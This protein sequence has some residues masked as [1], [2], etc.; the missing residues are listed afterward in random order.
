MKSRFLLIGWFLL[1]I[2]LTAIEATAENCLPLVV[3]NPEGNYIVP[4][5]MGD[6]V[7]SRVNGTELSLDA[8]VQKRRVSRPAVVVIHGGG[9]T[10]GS[11]V[12][13]TGQFLEML[14]EAGYNWFA[15]DYRKNGSA[16]YQQSLAD[17]RAALQFIRCH[18]TAFRIDP[19]RIALLGED[20]G[21]Q[22]A[23]LL[24]ADQTEDVKASVLIGG[25]YDREELL[26]APGSRAATLVVHGSADREALPETAQ[27][28]C[29]AQ[30]A[31]GAVCDYVSVEGAIH[32][33][34]NWRPEQ[35]SYKQRVIRW[36]NRK[37][38]L[39]KPDFEPYYGTLRWRS[40]FVGYVNDSGKT[41]HL[42]LNLHIPS[43]PGPFPVVIL[44]HG[45]GWEAGDKVTYIAPLFEPLAKAGFAW[46]SIDYELTPKV[47]HESQL[48]NVRHAIDWIRNNASLSRLD[49]ERIALIGESA[50]GQMVAQLATESPRG[51][52]AVVSFY[53]VYDFTQMAKDLSPRSIPVRL[54]RLN[55]LDDEAREILRRYSP[56]NNVKKEMPPLLLICGTKDGLFAQHTAFIEKLQQVGATFDSIT[57][58]GAPHGMENWEGHSA[59]MHYKPQ[60]IAWLKD[61]LQHK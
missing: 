36:L 44:V 29:Q 24:S 35:W 47:P 7:Y 9:F 5:V 56:R 21:A 45:G 11:R 14:T 33:P 57:L 26:S 40:P 37:L 51:V 13:F 55:R 16:N 54:F 43:G 60:L 19:Q 34:E 48:T 58:E 50:S 41:H 15:I 28:Y 20:T 27:R 3:R 6:I 61:Q 2:C 46:A 17:V 42:Q 39:A 22:L 31:N 38:K 49:P 12:S 23:A 18:A 25:V 8:Y 30:K 10:T 59:W 1:A 4:G 32:C 53:G 52:T